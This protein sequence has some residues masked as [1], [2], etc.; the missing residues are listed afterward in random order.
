MRSS[1]TSD[2]FHPSKE[3]QIYEQKYQMY[4]WE[5]QTCEQIY[6]IYYQEEY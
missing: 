4:M 3:Y 6:Q 5:Y 1:Y 2:G